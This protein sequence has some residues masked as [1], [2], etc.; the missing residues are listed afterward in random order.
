MS[1]V[2]R[3]LSHS[4][5]FILNSTTRSVGMQQLMLQCIVFYT[6][7]AGA[8]GNYKRQLMRNPKNNDLS[9]HIL[10]NSAT[11]VGVCIMVISIVK[12]L[13]VDTVNYFIDKAIGY[14]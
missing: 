8:V 7:N 9:H 4:N 11:M 14:G 6:H 3:R 1:S 10:S 12:S 2:V 5:R 13:P